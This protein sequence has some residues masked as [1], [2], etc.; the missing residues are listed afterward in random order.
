MK[1]S[2]IYLFAL[3]TAVVSVQAQEDTRPTHYIGLDAG[4]GYSHL[5]FGDIW[6]P[7]RSVAKPLSGW[8]VN[9]SLFYEVDYRHFLFHTGLGVEFLSG[10][11]QLPIGDYT[12]TVQEYP[13]MAYHYSFLQFTEHTRYAVAHVP[14]MVGG[15][16]DKMYFL[17]GAKLG[18]Y[19]FGGT[20]KMQSQVQTWATDDDIIDPLYNLPTHDM[21]TFQIYGTEQSVKYPMFNA[22]LSAEIGLNL[23]K[24]AWASEKERK[25]MDRAQRYRNLRKKKSLRERTHVRLAL[26]ADYGISD[27]HTYQA[28][29]VSEGGNSTGGIVAFNSLTDLQPYSMLGYSEHQDVPLHNFLLGVKVTLRF[30]MPKKAPKKGAMANP[31]LYVYTTDEV[32]EKPL[33]GTRIQIFETIKQHRIRLDKATDN[34]YARVGKALPAGTYKVYASRG[35]H[36][37]T[38]TITFQHQDAYDTLYVALYPYANLQTTVT[39]A[40]SL[41]PVAAQVT[42]SRLDGTVVTQTTTDSLHNVLTSRIDDRETYIVHAT[43]DNYEPFLDTISPKT[44]EVNVALEP[45]KIRSF[46]LHN[47]Y[48]A[49]AQTRILPSSE[50]ALQELYEMLHENPDVTIRIIGHTD[51]VGSDASNQT[52]SEGRAKSVRQEM[53]KRGISG[54][55]IQTTGHGE[56]D[57]IVP[58]DS[59][60]HRQ[61]NR[62]VEIQVLTG[63][64]QVHTQQ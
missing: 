18:F 54:K 48:F 8:G 28:N 11:N 1:K 56:K 6:R 15:Q 26:F 27:L 44:T 45:I 22:M 32:T 57:P 19:P 61:M 47:M 58:N 21:R 35:S 16:W 52:L 3:L 13:S 40:R 51:D 30:E 14:I 64:V 50:S 7:Y 24:R 37:P 10:R 20:T 41:R 17:V 63:T 12:A 36:L 38:D 9:G 31:Y 42:I 4:V 5:F 33:S 53:I 39:D 34:K 46:V 25:R 49:T 43:A 2:F 55:R 60:A 23:D 59:D 29:P 62:R